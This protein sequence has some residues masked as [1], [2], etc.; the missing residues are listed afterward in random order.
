MFS[1][2]EDSR[3]EKALQR[4][5]HP[6]GPSFYL[7][8]YADLCDAGRFLFTLFPKRGGVVTAFENNRTASFQL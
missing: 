2:E 8:F 3:E 6:C 5:D 7:G 4:K 1:E